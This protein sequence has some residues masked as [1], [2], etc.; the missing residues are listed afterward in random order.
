MNSSIRSTHMTPDVLK[1]WVDDN[2][3]A[4][5]NKYEKE[6]NCFSTASNF[7][8][9]V[10]Q[11]IVE[12]RM[13]LDSEMDKAMMLRHYRIELIHIFEYIKVMENEISMLTE[14][15]HG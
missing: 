15:L 3:R 5:I 8:T 2:A 9:A 4:V 12:L 7:I 11:E 10:H 6:P 13:T 1:K 14:Q